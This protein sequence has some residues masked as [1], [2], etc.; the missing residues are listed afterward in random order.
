MSTPGMARGGGLLGHA[1]RPRAFHQSMLQYRSDCALPV[2]LQYTGLVINQYT[3]LQNFGGVFAYVYINLS[4]ALPNCAP[5][6][7]FTLSIFG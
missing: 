4:L 3:P 7:M 5:N 1:S 2:L 6:N